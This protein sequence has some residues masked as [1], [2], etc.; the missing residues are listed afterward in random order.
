MRLI[1]ELWHDI[2]VYRGV[3]FTG[4]FEISSKGRLKSCARWV[5]DTAGRELENLGLL[6]SYSWIWTV[7][8]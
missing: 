2:G 1:S 3:D 4:V 7:T 5:K 8:S 6:Q